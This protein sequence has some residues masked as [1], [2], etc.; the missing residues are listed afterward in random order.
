M[1]KMGR[2]EMRVA[3]V[4]ERERRQERKKMGNIDGIKERLCK[5]GIKYERE[6]ERA[7]E[8]WIERLC[9]KKG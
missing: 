9:R 5:K 8:K 1:L 4:R 7:N 6:R 3:E 2:N